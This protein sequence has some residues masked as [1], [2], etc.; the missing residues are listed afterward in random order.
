MFYRRLVQGTYSRKFKWAIWAAIA[1]VIA[2]TISFFVIICIG[3]TPFE[4]VWQQYNTSWVL[5]HP[6]YKCA[7]RELNIKLAEL[8][9][10]LSV[11]TDFYSVMLPAALI[12]QI[13]LNTRQ[14]YGLFFIFGIG[15][16]LVLPS[17]YFR[18]SSQL[19]ALQRC[20]SWS[21]SHN[22]SP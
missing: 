6:T 15:F 18:Y 13:R 5:K 9:G 3:C 22:I 2:Y 17:R 4:A 20:G 19:M 14:K 21:R 10:G 8:I 11:V 16:L 1:F 12:M 7:S